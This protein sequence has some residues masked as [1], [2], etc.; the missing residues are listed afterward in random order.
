MYSEESIVVVVINVHHV[1]HILVHLREWQ[2][3]AEIFQR[4]RNLARLQSAISVSVILLECSS[5]RLIST[6]LDWPQDSIG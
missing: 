1:M 6:D 5:P 2:T 3:Q 4:S